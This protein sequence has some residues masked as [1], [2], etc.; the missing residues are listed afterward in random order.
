MSYQLPYVS[1]RQKYLT[2][3]DVCQVILPVCGGAVVLS[4]SFRYLIAV[5]KTSTAVTMATTAWCTVKEHSHADL[6]VCLQSST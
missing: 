6:H 2:L 4:A 5:T 1:N 3:R